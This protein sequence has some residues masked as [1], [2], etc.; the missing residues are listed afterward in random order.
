MR[1][2]IGMLGLAVLA[3]LAV[4]STPLFADPSHLPTVRE[5]MAATV[6]TKSIQQEYLSG[7]RDTQ[8]SLVRVHTV[9]DKHLPAPPPPPPPRDPLLGKV[10]IASNFDWKASLVVN[11]IPKSASP[12]TSGA[13]RFL[14][15]PGQV[16]K[17]DPIVNFGALAM[18]LHQ[19]FGNV[20]VRPTSTY[21]TLR[22]E[23]ASTCM[24][25]VNRSAYWMPA[26]LDGVGNVVRPDYVSIYYKRRPAS[27]PKCNPAADPKAEGICVAIPNGLKFVFGWNQQDPAGPKTG[28]GYFNCQGPGSTSAHYPDIDAVTPFCP[29]GAQMGAVITAPTCWDGKN[30]DSPDH[31]SHMAYRSYGSWGYP[32]CPST[33][34][35]VLP[36][37]TMGVWYTVD[38]NLPIWSLASDPHLPGGKRGSTFHADF[39]MAWD[40]EV[41]RMW[42][43]GCINQWLNCAEG[44]LGNGFA[45]KQEWPFEW[46]ANPRLVPAPTT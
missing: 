1:R 29:V 26:M 5:V 31:R 8:P 22:K 25:P 33:H 35:F 19:F 14:C 40:P 44:T 32:K 6:T 18:H 39:M 21:E 15:M 2:I 3:W 38:A 13:F 17:I 45:M 43:D 7:A 10:D 30:L 46:R 20:V 42:H 23:G 9:L 28:A 36:A 4:L 12:D 27:D 11:A 41:K 37:F 34:P 24:S 16:A